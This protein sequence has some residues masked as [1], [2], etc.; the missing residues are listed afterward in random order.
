VNPRRVAALARRRAEREASGTA[1]DAAARL[2]AF[3]YP[4]Q[5][6][7]YTSP[8]KQR[9]TRK[10]RR[11]GATAGGCA[12][13]LARALEVP[14]FRAT[15][16]NSTRA[17]VRALFWESD[18]QSGVIDLLREHATPI[19]G[20]EMLT[21]RLG[22]VE[23]ECRQAEMA[24]VFSNGGRVDSFGADHARDLDKLRGRAKHVIW[25]DEAQK[26]R[27][28]ERFSRAVVSPALRDFDGELWLTGTPDRDC[29]GMFYD[30]TRNDRTPDG[31]DVHA[32]SVTMNPRFGAS[33][34]ERWQ[35]TAAR[36]LADNGWTEDDPDFRREWLAQWVHE[37]ARF[38]YAAH[39]VPMHELTFAPARIAA[40]GFP[41]LTEALADLP[42]ADL[43]REYF[44]A[45]GADLGTRDDFAFVIWA[46]SLQD[47]VLYELASWKRPG[48][49][50]D[51]MAACLRAVR[52]QV[53]IGIVTADAGGGGKPAV[54]GWSKEWADRYGLPIVEATKQNKGMAIN[55][56]NTE[57]RR[58]RL[59]LRAGGVLLAEWLVHRW[60]SLRSASGLQV[61]E[62]TT[63]NHASDAALYAFRE[64]YSYRFR[65]PDPTVEPGT[66]AWAL[67][68]E[69][70]LEQDALDYA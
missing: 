56:V 20:R 7:F 49:D 18:T 9:A 45:L 4:E 23:V 44:L 11:A 40:D 41:D 36:A 30:V 14:G 32:L 10:T 31:W 67:R 66:P 48:L 5:R 55:Q 43:G 65:E 39:A 34:A 13:L 25:V 68:E 64:S 12:E 60:A 46:W 21:F 22:G 2:R 16:C 15:Y 33:A 38:V 1:A 26:F 17:E 29:S 57:V 62:P 61:E 47:P 70:E 53:G 58:R 28:L 52:E 59:K 8:A 54:M 69:A 37:D 63:P 42:G 19:E 50:Y 27:F 24:L 3:Y 6:A 35:R 51:E